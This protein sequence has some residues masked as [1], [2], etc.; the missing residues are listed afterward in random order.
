MDYSNIPKIKHDSL[1]LIIKFKTIDI[2][3]DKIDLALKHFKKNTNIEEIKKELLK[4]P[5]VKNSEYNYEINTE[6]LT[7]DPLLDKQWYFD[8]NSEYNL[9]ITPAGYY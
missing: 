7:N 5:L 9:N 1:T 4:N 3:K 8:L 6:A 2:D